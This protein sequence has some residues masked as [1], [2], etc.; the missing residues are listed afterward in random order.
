MKNASMILSHLSSQPQFN[1]PFEE[2]YA[3]PRYGIFESGTKKHHQ[4]P[5][6]QSTG[7]FLK[8]SSNKA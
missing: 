1:N 6:I 8:D 7:I 5:R 4:A 2:T 3:N